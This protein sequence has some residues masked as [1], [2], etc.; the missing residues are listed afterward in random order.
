MRHS[1]LNN[2]QS[3]NFFIECCQQ[4]AAK[5]GRY[6]ENYQEDRVRDMINRGRVDEGVL[7]LYYEKDVVAFT[8][9]ESYKEKEALMATRLC[10]YNPSPV[11]YGAFFLV[12]KVLEIARERGYKYA[13]GS[14]NENNKNLVRLMMSGESKFNNTPFEKYKHML[15][16]CFDNFI[17]GEKQIHNG[18]EQQFY[19]IK[20]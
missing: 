19:F 17:V 1:F 14:V 8:G 7:Y 13:A 20:V 4:Y 2:T 5:G 6:A 18:V 16:D 12:P 15:K 11:P 9:L 3:V 10:V